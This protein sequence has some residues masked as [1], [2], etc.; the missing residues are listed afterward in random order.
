MLFWSSCCNITSIIR[1]NFFLRCCLASEISSL[2]SEYFIHYTSANYLSNL[3]CACCMDVLFCSF[4]SFCDVKFHVT[5]LGI[6]IEISDVEII[7]STDSL[8][9]QIEVSLFLGEAIVY[10][11]SLIL[12]I[13]RAI[14]RFMI[15]LFAFTICILFDSCIF[16]NFSSK[17][18]SNFF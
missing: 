15:F 12:I 16:L 5:D 8:W 9:F 18:P 4:I 11:L 6:L 10:C 17:M 7:Q 1:N 2:N 14:T 13:Y 3:F